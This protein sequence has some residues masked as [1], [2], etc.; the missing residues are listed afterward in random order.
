MMMQLVSL[1]K[2]KLAL[3]LLRTGLI[4]FCFHVC[5]AQVYVSTLED[6][7]TA[8]TNASVAEVVLTQSITL[9]G[10]QL[11]VN[12]GIV[13]RG[14][15]G[16]AT[17]CVIDAAGGSRALSYDRALQ[18]NVEADVILEFSGISFLNGNAEESGGCVLIST[19]GVVILSNVVVS[20]C[21]SQGAAGGLSLEAARVDLVQATIT[22]NLAAGGSGGGLVMA[23]FDD[24]DGASR[25]SLTDCTLEGNVAGGGGGGG[26]ALV[27]FAEVWVLGLLA[28][29][30]WAHGAGGGLQLERADT[31]ELRASTVFNCS[32]GGAGGG[33][34]L[35]AAQ[36][37]GGVDTEETYEVELLQCL[38]ASNQA[39]GAAG[40]GAAIRSLR[41]SG[42]TAQHELLVNGCTF[43]GNTARGG[44]AGVHATNGSLLAV[45]GSTLY[46]NNATEDGSGGGGLAEAFDAVRALATER[47]LPLL[48]SEVVNTSFGTNRAAQG[49]GLFLAGVGDSAELLEVDF[50]GNQADSSAGGL[51]L[52]GAEGSAAAVSLTNCTF[53]ANEG[54]VDGGGGIV[55]QQLGEVVLTGVAFSENHAGG[56]GGGLLGVG[57]SDVELV[58]VLLQGN[59]AGGA[60]GGAKLED[61]TGAVAVEDTTMRD[62]RAVD[63]GGGLALVAVQG[64]VSLQRCHAENNTAGVDGG[65]VSIAAA[66]AV[67]FEACSVL[68]NLA[69]GDGGGLSLASASDVQLEG[70]SVSNNSADGDGGGAGIRAA[71]DVR[72]ES[73]TVLGNSAGGNGG[74]VSIVS[75][76]GIEL[77]HSTFEENSALDRGGG[78]RLEALGGDLEV[79]Q[80]AFHNNTA[81]EASGGGLYASDGGGAARVLDS[82]FEDNRAGTAGSVGQV[83]DGA[84]GALLDFASATLER[85]V[86]ARNVAQGSGGGWMVEKIGVMLRVGNST[87]RDNLAGV[88]GG[89]LSLSNG[90]EVQLEDVVLA[91]NIGMTHGGGASVRSFFTVDVSNVT[92]EG[93]QVADYDSLG[94]G[95]GLTLRGGGTAAV[96]ACQFWRGEAGAGGAVHAASAHGEAVQNCSL[97]LQGCRLENNTA[98]AGP[99]GGL[100]V[101]WTRGGSAASA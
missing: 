98:S 43:T 24:D 12:H 58:A 40:G 29:H 81:A 74:G 73:C 50:A 55:L 87:A 11:Q 9:D 21:T 2:R 59:T 38:F 97:A 14:E 34:H 13:F 76:A 35:A 101:D 51:A 15:C 28:Q 19:G 80:C 17:G 16:G 72:A 22:G 23:A 18:G 32:S 91:N 66:A 45:T 99:G 64:T 46:G 53:N 52:A 20:G 47:Q 75:V 60:G 63:A 44:G 3:T 90:Q 33:L 84:G 10:T 7:R 100:L 8:L 94:G 96:A 71:A 26:A 37:G 95:L 85:C 93:N 92:F 65:G 42:Q 86:L 70:C 88:A 41:G 61:V 4:A 48:S 39:Q 69:A 62:N 25:A 36:G 49:A 79:A 77:L 5:A 57:L 27:G 89:G 54:G 67:R 68:G 78:S 83:G 31:V 56:E 30:N 1:G 82:V 6:L